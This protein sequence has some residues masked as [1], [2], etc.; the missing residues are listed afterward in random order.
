MSIQKLVD[1]LL[2][3]IPKKHFDIAYYLVEERLRHMGLSTEEYEYAVEYLKE[4]IFKNN[5]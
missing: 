1:S 2:K 4:K 3:E 5:Y